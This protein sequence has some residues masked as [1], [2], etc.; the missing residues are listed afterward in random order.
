MAKVRE[1]RFEYLKLDGI[2]VK[3]L[4]ES[5]A[6][7]EFVSAL[8]KLAH[9]IGVEVIAEFVQ[10]EATMEFLAE[11]GIEYAQGYYLGRPEPFSS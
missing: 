4:A 11:C 3:D 1:L 2:L 9:D 5:E 7:R 6:D 8:A 10:D